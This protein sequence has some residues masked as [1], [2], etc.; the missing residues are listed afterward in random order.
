MVGYYIIMPRTSRVVIEGCA[1]HV[2][3]R[4]N[5]RQDVFFVDDD[6]RQF[7]A[8]LAEAAERFGLTVDGYCLMTNHI[9]LVVTPERQS[10]LADAL[11]RTNQLYAQYVNR[12]HGR[13]GHLWQDRFFSCA[14][15]EMH[16]WRAM[17]YI[18]RNPVRAR[19]SRKAWS[20]PWSS[21]AGHC[22]GDDLTGLL[23]LSGWH[24]QMDAARWC[25]LLTRDD[26]QQE[27]TRFRLYTGR[28]RPL[29]SDKFVAKLETL[30]GRRLRPL[31][32]GR[33]AKNRVRPY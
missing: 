14:L 16:R 30:L 29:G 1:H 33:P 22:G 4:G 20:W 32:H 26:D 18:E 10:S 24:E 6:R 21:A 19:L 12:F 2:T 8:L 3:Q 31:P 25:D 28:G 15:D 9:H 13:S 5:N 11:K 23:D 27:L 17:V 7:L